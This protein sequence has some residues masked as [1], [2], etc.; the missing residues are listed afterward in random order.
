MMA[1]ALYTFLSP[2]LSYAMQLRQDFVA[3]RATEDKSSLREKNIYWHLTI[4]KL[5]I[6]ESR[7]KRFSIS[8]NRK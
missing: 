6:R 8:S 4:W 1:R 2:P 7:I 5:A 3:Q